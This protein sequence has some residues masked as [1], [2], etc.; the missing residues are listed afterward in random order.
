[1]RNR[2]PLVAFGL[3][4]L[5][6]LVSGNASAQ[7]RSERPR[8]FLTPARLATLKAAGKKGDVADLATWLDKRIANPTLANATLDSTEPG[9]VCHNAA[10]IAA[11]TGETKYIDAAKAFVLRVAGVPLVN[12]DDTGPRNRALCLAIG[13]DWL[14]ASLSA[15]DRTT[16]RNAILANVAA[17]QGYVDKPDFVSG[18]TRWGNATTLAAAISVHGDT[19]ALDSNFAKTSAN[20]TGGY[21]LVLDDVGQTGGHHMGWQYGASYASVTPMLVWQSATVAAELWSPS[22]L[23][24]AAYFWL[25]AANGVGE[26]PLS[27]DVYTEGLNGDARDL[28]A[29]SAALGNAHA[30]SFFQSLPVAW[31]PLRFIRILTNTGGLKASP[32]EEL[33]LS[34][35]FEGSGFHVVRDA[36][37]RA[38]AT[39]AVFKSSPF[40]SYGHHHRD[41]GSL[42]IDYR[43]GLLTEGGTYDNY[44]TSHHANYF[45][46]SVAHNT[47]LVHWPE[48]PIRES[49]SNDGGQRIAPDWSG[50]PTKPSDLHTLAKLGG[51][52]HATDAGACVWSRANVGPAYAKEKVTSYER[53]ILEARTPGGA[54]HPAFFVVDRTTL[55]IARDA[56]ILWHFVDAPTIAGNRLFASNAGGGGLSIEVLR[57]AN[58]KFTSYSGVNRYRVGATV[59]DPNPN[60]A[61]PRTT[62]YWGRVEVA[63]PS[64]ELSPTWT[65]LLRVGDKASPNDGL[66]A[67]DLAGPGWLGARVGNTVFAVASSPVTALQLPDGPP[68]AD[69]CIAGVTPN[70]VL[71][72]SVGGAKAVQL[73]SNE[74]GVVVFDPSKH[75]EQGGTGAGGGNASV[76]ASGATGAT[77]GV[78]GGNGTNGAT[79]GSGGASGALD[80]Q[81]TADASCAYHHAA[82]PNGRGSAAYV[83]AAAIAL[84]ILEKRRN[85][86]RIAKT[87]TKR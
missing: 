49:A 46:R 43:G 27:G 73:M 23:K 17:T 38:T 1:M 19:T 76:S 34:R 55:P 82:T 45:T 39:T 21:N 66:V 68:L 6:Y 51:L 86:R 60:G 18:H 78:G 87:P 71:A 56:A 81:R 62:P 36:W 4:V 11:V 65:T 61:N 42:V 33:P 44:G 70:A 12:G 50:E 58:A 72:I 3:G 47:L 32:V 16:I 57:P 84:G 69:G 74:D 40:Y 7:L 48:E 75:I 52:T 9:T 67:T 22:V 41:E 64:Q 24:D 20:F 30:E 77:T 26:Y 28:I 5:P 37:D 63:P 31:E 79:A 29:T 59:Y 10:L 54:K 8:L 35:L 85:P 14:Y 53:D 83:L 25:Y 13:Y 15:N 2:F 80:E